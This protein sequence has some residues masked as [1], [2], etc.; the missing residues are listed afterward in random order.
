[1]EVVA[2]PGVIVMTDVVPVVVVVVPL[3]VVIFVV[4][5]S[6]PGEDW[7]HEATWPTIDLRRITIQ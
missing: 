2:L 3:V 7:V 4:V 5:L 1:M 6:T